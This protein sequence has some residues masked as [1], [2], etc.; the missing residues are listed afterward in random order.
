MFEAHDRLGYR[1]TP[2]FE[3]YFE[4]IYGGGEFKTHV[5]I[6]SRGFRD[7]EYGK[8]AYNVFR[9]LVIGDSHTFGWG[10][11]EQDCWV[12]LLENMLNK[13]NITESIRYEVIN[14]G[15]PGYSND[16]EL[17]IFRMNLDLEP[18]MV[19]LGYCIGSD[20][21][22]NWVGGKDRFT[23]VNG[24]WVYNT[25]ANKSRGILW[26]V[27]AFL[28]AH[29]HVYNFIRVRYWRLKKMFENRLQSRDELQNS[30]DKIVIRGAYWYEKLFLKEY[31]P[32]Q[33]QAW[34][35][36]KQILKEMFVTA[37]KNNIKMGI[38]LIPLKMQV[39]DAD[40]LEQKGYVLDKPNK[41]VIQYAKKYDVFV[42]D[43]YPEFRKI[44][45]HKKLYLKFD[46][47]WQKH[48]HVIAAR[49]IYDKL[50]QEIHKE[51]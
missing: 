48:T 3:G 27:K 39:E 50:I 36:T 8:K 6:N 45:K 7:K 4:G 11:E 14:A 46:P 38:V 28:Y 13:N 2:G 31:I 9:I 5:K 41:I 43:L 10:V 32:Q 44:A 30:S 29:S 25:V 42:V 12:R 17:E 40:I 34:K 49:I 16:Q 24:Y 23:V 35:L 15:V 47:H 19:L 21:G 26:N 33:K 51:L 37:K 20:V 18:D 22:E 1:L